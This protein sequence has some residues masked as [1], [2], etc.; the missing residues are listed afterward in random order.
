MGF[1]SRINLW[2]KDTFDFFNKH[3]N[4]SRTRLPTEGRDSHPTD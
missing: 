2:F 1:F 4:V 3:E